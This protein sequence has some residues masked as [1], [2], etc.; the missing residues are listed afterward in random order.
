M[1]E[2]ETFQHYQVLKHPDG[3]LWEL[4]RGAMGVTYKAFDTNL[5]CQVALKVINTAYL[6]SDM[7]RQRF[8]REARAAA[9]LSHPNVASVFHLGEEGGN[10]FYAMEFINGETL[11]AFVRRHGPLPPA[12][13][14]RITLQVARALRAASREGLVHRDIKPANLMLLHEDDG[15]DEQGDDDLHVKV[16][17]FGLAKVSRKDGSEASATLTTAGFVGTPHFASPEQLEEKDLDVRSDIYSLGVTLWYML[18]GRPPFSGGMVQIMSQHLTRTPPFGQLENLPP[19]VVRLLERMLEKDAAKRPQTATDLRRD[20]EAAARTLRA[21]TAPGTAG[22]GPAGIGM[23]RRKRRWIRRFPRRRSPKARRSPRATVTRRPPS[24]RRAWSWRAAIRILR[25]VADGAHGTLFQAL[26][27]DHGRPVALKVL[28]PGVL[29][30]PEEFQRAETVVAQTRAA[31]HPSLLEIYSLERAGTRVFVTC[32]WVNGFTLVDLLRNRGALPLDEALRCLEPLAAA[33][34]HARQAGLPELDF[35]PAQVLLAFEATLDLPGLSSLIGTPLTV[36]PAFRPKVYPLSLHFDSHASAPTAMGLQTVV[37]VDTAR[38]GSIRQLAT[39]VYEL[40]G[41]SPVRTNSKRRGHPSPRCRNAATPCLRQALSTEAPASFQ[42]ASAMIAALRDSFLGESIGARDGGPGRG[43]VEGRSD[44]RVA[45]PPAIPLSVA[46]AA[47]RTRCR[48]PP[49]AD[50][51]SGA[52]RRAFADRFHRARGHWGRFLRR[53][54]N[55]HGRPIPGRTQ[56]RKRTRTIA[57]TPGPTVEPRRDRPPRRRP[58]RL[59]RLV[60]PLPRTA[61]AAPGKCLRKPTALER[62]GDDAGALAA[63]ARVAEDY[64]DS[65]PGVE[66]AR[67]LHQPPARPGP[68]LEPTTTR[69]FCNASATRW[70]SRPSSGRMRPWCSSATICFPPTLRRRPSGTGRPPPRGSRKPCWRWATCIPAGWA[71]PWNPP[72]RRVGTSLPATRAMPRPRSISRML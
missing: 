65:D 51:G 10:Y 60:P 66:P 53:L 58:P 21:D 45:T 49:Q 6:D 28:K 36:W 7:A 61:P 35:S 33:A 23:A 59:R 47:L 30:A 19:A 46:P 38:P 1:A 41:G 42:S 31:R 25:T 55:F 8:L 43:G 70:N 2:T 56:D 15:D 11:E 48:L 14:L 64:P 16:I 67:F 39:L 4:G 27:L 68:S 3:S 44:A 24:P 9:G 22:P 40:L 26:E 5:R 18:T 17:D 62:Q 54:E 29:T 13:A 52:A 71:S 34:D 50:T 12:F 20:I 57:S 69:G 37:P 63:Y 72:R 32:E